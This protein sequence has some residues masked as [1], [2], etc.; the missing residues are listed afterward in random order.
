MTKP[1]R[2]GLQTLPP[3]FGL[4]RAEIERALY[5][6]LDCCKPDSTPGVPMAKL[7]SSNEEFMTDPDLASIV[8]ACAANRIQKLLEI[9]SEDLR[10]SRPINWVAWRLVDP[11]RIFVK[12][13]PHKF[14]KA[15]AGR[16]RLIWCISLVDQLVERFLYY[17]VTKSEIASHASIPSRP[18]MSQTDEGI[19]VTRASI[20]RLLQKTGM[21][22]DTDVVAWDM[23][24]KYWLML[25]AE[26]SYYMQL[27]PQRHPVFRDYVRLCRTRSL[28]ASRPCV[29]LS[30]GELFEIDAEEVDGAEFRGMMQSGRFVTSWLNS[31]CRVCLA[32]LRGAEAQAMGDDCLET[33][34]EDPAPFYA[35]LGFACESK[36]HE[37]MAG[38]QFCSTRFS[39][40]GR[41]DGA[42]V[43]WSRTLYRLL[44]KADPTP[45]EVHQFIYETRHL[46]PPLS[47]P[48]RRRLA[49]R[50]VSP[51]D[52]R[53][54]GFDES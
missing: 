11:T 54:L 16:W 9:D 7:A 5:F 31:R 27:V 45:E 37:S 2:Y 26:L 42:P 18:G 6:H 20:E 21:I 22:A 32:A 1:G 30:N 38:V 43:R 15:V 13:E 19:A 8:V 24:L 10:F 44:T 12:Q 17:H 4:T 34:R 40:E 50:A 53:V 36:L 48:F 47:E 33:T 29:V 23:T 35:S 28:L 14:A 49:Q 52:L 39:E 3:G 41:K 25:T 46:D 51:E